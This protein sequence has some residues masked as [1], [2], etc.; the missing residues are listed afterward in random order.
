[1]PFPPIERL[2][3]YGIL[4]VLVLA[5]TQLAVEALPKTYLSPVD[6]VLGLLALVGAWAA[7]RR[8]TAQRLHAPSP[9]AIA[10]VLFG[11]LSIPGASNRGAALKDA[12][13]WGLYFVAAWMLFR[14]GLDEI[15]TRRAGLALAACMTLLILALA[16]IQ[17][18]RTGV[19]NLAVRATFGNHNVLSGFLALALPFAY[20]R[21]LADDSP[22]ARIAGLLLTLAGVAVLLSGAA[23][24]GVLLALGAMSALRGRTALALTLGLVL[25]LV[26]AL[27]PRLPRRGGLADPWLDSVALHDAGGEL[28]RR[29]PD[30]ECAWLMMTQHPWRGVGAG[31]YQERISAYRRIPT[32]PGAPEPD[33]QNLYLVLGATLGLPGLLAFAALLLEGMA[34][35][36][37]AAATAA[38]L[39]P[40]DR[41]LALGAFGSLLAFAAAAIWHPLLVRGIGIPLVGVLALAQHLRAQAE[42]A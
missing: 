41:P 21:V 6:P 12:A 32:P 14:Y 35:A 38:R 29:Y 4:L 7:V 13:Q 37:G 1:M 28:S 30:W 17:F 18:F 11:L 36:A 42:R 24:L 31:N 8:L 34:Q 9:F 3:H 15:R 27:H 26:A 39:P 2:F 33:T 25:L 19:P 20:A 10:F 16:L 23:V 22:P 40:E 5:P